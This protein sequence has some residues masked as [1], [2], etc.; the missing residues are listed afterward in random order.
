MGYTTV[1]VGSFH[2]TPALSADRR[3][4][5]NEWASQR[6]GD[7][8]PS[9]VPGSFYCQWVVSQ[10]GSK[11]EWHKGEK[12]YGYKKWLQV[13][14]Q[15]FVVPWGVKL[16]GKMYWCGEAAKDRGYIRALQCDNSTVFTTGQFRM[17]SWLKQQVAQAWATV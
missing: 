13:L 10:D 7:M 16:T 2:L 12:F 4:Q 15:R 5:V 17:T 1:L 14:N 8:E 11:L 6:F 3:Q 9:I